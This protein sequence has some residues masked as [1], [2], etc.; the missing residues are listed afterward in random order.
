MGNEVPHRVENSSRRFTRIG[1]AGLVEVDQMK[2]TRLVQRLL[3]GL[4]RAMCGY[5]S[6]GEMPCNW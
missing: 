1:V 2:H 5:F 6:L 3:D 4:Q